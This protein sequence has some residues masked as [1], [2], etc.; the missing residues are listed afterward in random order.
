MGIKISALPSI[1]TP[2]MSDIFPVV[3]SGVTYKESFTQLSSLFATAGVNSNIT[4]LSGLTTPLSADQ[5]GT[6]V[7]NGANNL[8]LAGDLNTSGAFSATLTFTGA[9]NVTFPTS[10][11]LATTGSASGTVNTGNINELAYYTATGNAVSGLITA[12]SSI[13]VTNSSGV[14][15]LSTTLPAFLLGGTLSTNGQTITN[16]LTDGNVSFATNGAGLFE[17][18]STQGITGISNDGFLTADSATLVP[19]QAAVKA[20]VDAVAGGGFTVIAPAVV[21][22]TTNFSGVYANGAAG[23][24]A[25]ITQSVA[26]VV[27]ID[28]VTLTINQRVLFTGQTDPAENGVYQISTLGTGAVQAIFTRVTDYDEASEILPGTLVPVTSGT[29]YGGSIW[30]Q[31]QTV[32]TVG[33]DPIEFVIFAQPANTYVTL[34]T[35]Q[36]ITGVKSFDSGSLILKGATS[37]TSVF[38]AA[39]IAGTTTF[40]LP[41]TSGTIT[42]LGNTATGTGSVVLQTSPTV[43]LPTIS[44]LSSNELLQFTATASA[45][46]N[47]QITNAATGGAPVIAAV[48]SDADILQQISGKGTKGAGVQGTSTNDNAVT[49]NVGEFGDTTQSGLIIVAS[50]PTTVASVLLQPGD[51]DINGNVSTITA[52]VANAL[53]GGISL[54]NNTFGAQTASIVMTSNI[55]AGQTSITVPTT[56]ISIAVATTVYLVGQINNGGG[57]PTIKGYMSWRRVR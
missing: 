10:G 33:T 26:A 9:T 7:N 36:N 3:Q 24:G 18:N 13:L 42:A 57:N 49:G 56:R 30:L 55:I 23:V 29:T 17:L 8:T 34:A 38:N 32:V 31:T 35:S 28:G 12:N 21:A 6:G 16:S 39:G 52:Q 48:G 44:D 54:V 5:G 41:T 45:V 37:G 27:T 4:S 46:N 53:V 43:L 47:V 15:G 19:T 14:P 25:T 22:Q 40:T 2:S 50:T 11:T 1:V 51:Y 20:Y